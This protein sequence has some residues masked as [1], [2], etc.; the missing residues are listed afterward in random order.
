MREEEIRIALTDTMRRVREASGLTQQ[1]L[2]DRL[3]VGQSWVSRLE[4]A[5][6]DHR[7]ESVVTY[8][9]ALDAELVMAVKRNNVTY[10]VGGF[11]DDLN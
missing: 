11:G 9:A 4:S 1:Q 10:P 3:G 2:A 5:N 6:Y 8:F 7:V